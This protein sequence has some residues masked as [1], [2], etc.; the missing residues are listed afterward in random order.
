M[1]DHEDIAIRTAYAH[2]MDDEGKHTKKKPTRS[3]R[4]TFSYDQET[5]DGTVEETL[6]TVGKTPHKDGTISYDFQLSAPSGH[7]KLG[8]E[9]VDEVLSGGEDGEFSHN[10]RKAFKRYLRAEDREEFTNYF[11]KWRASR[12]RSTEFEGSNVSRDEAD[13]RFTMPFS[14]AVSTH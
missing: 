13:D 7:R 10:F 2:I 1:K 9:S 8:A 14:L 6:M 12:G 5:A 3:D 4:Y 11:D